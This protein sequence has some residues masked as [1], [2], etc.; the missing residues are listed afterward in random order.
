M[1]VKCL[2]SFNTF[3][4]SRIVSDQVLTWLCLTQSPDALHVSDAMPAVESCHEAVQKP[5]A[6]TQ[7]LCTVKPTKFCYSQEVTEH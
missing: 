6:E 4:E 1:Y 3:K 2:W 7:R 5:A